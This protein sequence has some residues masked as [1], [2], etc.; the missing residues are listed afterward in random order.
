MTPLS[1]AILATAPLY[2]VN[3]ESNI[4]HFNGLLILASGLKSNEGF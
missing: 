3:Q 1:T 4:R 2:G